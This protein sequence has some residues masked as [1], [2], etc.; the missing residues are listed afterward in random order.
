MNQKSKL[1]AFLRTL[2]TTYVIT[3][4]LLFVLAF[5]LYKFKLK[6][7]QVSLGVMA[8]YLLTCLFGGFLIGKSLKSKRFLWG[9]L[10]GLCYF[11]LLLGSS[12]LMNKGLNQ[13]L[14]NAVTTLLVCAGG[15][16]I[17]GMLS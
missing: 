9:F 16:T 8:I 4:I 12:Y 2:L 3:G 15:G 14:R 1:L 10:T 5:F 17:G 13:D 7:A 6:E 11:L